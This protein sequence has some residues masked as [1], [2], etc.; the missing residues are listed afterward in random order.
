MAIA[1][2]STLGAT[3]SPVGGDSHGLITHDG[4]ERIYLIHVPPS[5]EKSKSFPLVIALHGGNGNGQAMVDLTRGRFNALADKEGFIVVY[6]EGRR[7]PR[8]IQTRWNDGRDPRFS[9]ADDV[10]F[11]SALID[12]LGQTVNIDRHRVYATGISNGAHMVMRLARD[13]ADKIAAVA[14]VAYTMQEKFASAPVPRPIPLLVITGTK[15]PIVPREGGETPDATGERR[16][17]RVLSVPE[18]SK[19]LAGHDQCSPTPTVKVLPHNDPQDD[20]RVRQESWINCKDGSEVV[21]YAIEGGGHTWP[22][23][24]QYAVERAVGKTNRD[25]DASE[26]IWSFF[27]RHARADRQP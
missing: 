24:L 9:N 8:P 4:L 26:V 11:I 23:G 14:P 3:E 15:D 22:G 17:G 7:H 27:K 21:L 10:G 13:V 16:L 2:W 20:T 6:P 25:I 19:V 18:T 1:V 12:H 5:W